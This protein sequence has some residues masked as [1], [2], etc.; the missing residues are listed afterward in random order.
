[1]YF[2]SYVAVIHFSNSFRF[3]LKY[4]LIIYSIVCYFIFTSISISFSFFI[5]LFDIIMI[6]AY[7]KIM[8]FMVVLIVLKVIANNTSILWFD[9]SICFL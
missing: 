7:K 9:I 2:G 4:F 6:H 8:S 5:C 1:M 3:L